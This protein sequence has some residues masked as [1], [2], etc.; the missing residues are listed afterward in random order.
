VAGDDEEAVDITI[1]L[2]ETFPG[3]KGVR[4][5]PL[6]YSKVVELL[7]PGWILVLDKLNEGTWRTGYR[8]GE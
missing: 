3:F 2:V 1:A 6:K 5:G 8:I 4:A 7:G